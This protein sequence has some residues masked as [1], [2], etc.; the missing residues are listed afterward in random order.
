MNV[1]Y[2]ITTELTG[3]LYRLRE[4]NHR[5]VVVEENEIPLRMGI[6]VSRKH[7]Q[8]P[9]IRSA[10]TTATQCHSKRS[11]SGIVWK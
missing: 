1:V 11:K 5:N 9:T 3:V 10:K 7:C 2:L 4:L 6:T 8:R